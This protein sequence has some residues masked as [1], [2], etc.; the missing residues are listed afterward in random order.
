MDK[1]TKN[2]N[3]IDTSQLPT[4]KIKILVGYKPKIKCKYKFLQSIANRIFGY[5]SIYEEKN[6]KTF[7]IKASDYPKNNN[8]KEWNGD[9]EIDLS[10]ENL[11][12]NER[13]KL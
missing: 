7:F 1:I 13:E 9:L 5:E 6:C 11:N 8:W 12:I 10:I 2:S 4:Q 3:D